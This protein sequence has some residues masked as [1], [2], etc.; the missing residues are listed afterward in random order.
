M[1]LNYKTVKELGTAE[2]VEKKS[3]FIANVKPIKS[4]QEALEFIN[5][6][7]TKY[8]DARHNVHAYV[9]GDN[10]SIQRYSDDGEPSGTSGIPTLEVLLKGEIKNTV[11]VVTRYFGGILLGTGGL[12]RAYGGCAKKGVEAAKIVEKIL[13]YQYSI[14]L[15]YDMLG[16]VQNKLLENEALIRTIDYTD[17]V[18]MIFS[19]EPN[20]FEKLNHDMQEL[21]SGSIELLKISEDYVTREIH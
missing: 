1:L 20:K 17:K 4:E 12:V 21:T 18:N 14:D 10:N 16:K 3:K 13:C 5:E 15:N 2:I 6:I 19:I 11:I 7:K 9:L 8:W